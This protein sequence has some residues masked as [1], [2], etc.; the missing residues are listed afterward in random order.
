MSAMLAERAYLEDLWERSDVETGADVRVQQ[1]VRSNLFQLL[2]AA[3]RA[4][5]RGVPADGLTGGD[6]EGHY[7][8]DIEG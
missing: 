8:W 7:S 2:Q 4:D 3:A 1:A 5:A 6:H